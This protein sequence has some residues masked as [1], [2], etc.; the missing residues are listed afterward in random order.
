[1]D[2]LLGDEFDRSIGDISVTLDPV[3]ENPAVE[4]APVTDAPIDV[5]LDAEPATAGFD[6]LPADPFAAL[7][8][9]FEQ[10]DRDAPVCSPGLSRRV[11]KKLRQ[12]ARRQ[13]RVSNV[14][15]GLLH[16]IGAL[17]VPVAAPARYGAG[18]MGG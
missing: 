12:K 13:V 2:W 7:R 6:V 8:N 18:F 3:T 14:T 4:P 10:M 15:V 5:Q 17:P 11:G 9:A 1:M 16:N